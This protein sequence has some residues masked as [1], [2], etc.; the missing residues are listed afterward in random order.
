METPT[1]NTELEQALYKAGAQET[2]SRIILREVRL[3][4]G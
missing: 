3:G 4:D 1:V 2:Y